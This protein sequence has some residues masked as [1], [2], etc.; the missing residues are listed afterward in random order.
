MLGG[1]PGVAVAAATFAGGERQG[2]LRLAA[3]E[4][5]GG[6]PG[7][8]LIREGWERSSEAQGSFRYGLVASPLPHVPRRDFSC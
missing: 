7:E 2:I 1:Q 3:L 5:R 6:N 4:A 8:F